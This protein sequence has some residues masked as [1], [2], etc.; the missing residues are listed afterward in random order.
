LKLTTRLFLSYLKI[1]G[2]LSLLLLYIF[3][4]WFE[5]YALSLGIGTDDCN[6]ASFSLGDIILSIYT[7][8]LYLYFWVKGLIYFII[9]KKR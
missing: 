8:R 6:W 1:C 9:F 3:V 4:M 7:V 5:T 2:I